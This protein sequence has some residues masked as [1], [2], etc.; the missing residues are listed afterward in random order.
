MYTYV[1]T[2]VLMIMLLKVEQVINAVA[3]TLQLFVVLRKALNIITISTSFK[4][5]T[6]PRGKSAVLMSQTV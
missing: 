1:R 4:T 3:S 6:C 2:Y 5:T